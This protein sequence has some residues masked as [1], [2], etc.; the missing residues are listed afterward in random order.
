MLF[1]MTQ[2]FWNWLEHSIPSH[3]VVKLVLDDIQ[4]KI[5][6]LCCWHCTRTIWVSS[7]STFLFL[8]SWKFSRFALSNLAPWSYNDEIWDHAIIPNTQQLLSSEQGITY[9][10]RILKISVV[11]IRFSFTQFYYLLSS[12]LSSLSFTFQNLG[13]GKLLLMLCNVI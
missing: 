12:L 8:E 4:G 7:W 1:S 10:L 3:F 6:K 2:L 9:L 5:C 13:N 11:S